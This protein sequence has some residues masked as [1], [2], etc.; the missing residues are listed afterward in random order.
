M[1]KDSVQYLKRRCADV[2][3]P[4]KNGEQ[5][6]IAPKEQNPHATAHHWATFVH[7]VLRMRSEKDGFYYSEAHRLWLECTM[8]YAVAH[9]VCV[10]STVCVQNH[11]TNRW[12]TRKECSDLLKVRSRCV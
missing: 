9:I 2:M 12:V 10:V 3:V 5:K 6:A 7:P 1:G 11:W 8:D 4:C